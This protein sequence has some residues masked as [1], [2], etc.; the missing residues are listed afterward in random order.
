MTYEPTVK[1][2]GMYFDCHLTWA[3]H[4]KFTK[5]KSIRAINILK[6]VSG[7]NWGADQ[8]TL[9][10]LYNSLCKSILNYTYQIYSS[11]SNSNLK[12]LDVVHNQA[13]HICTQLTE[14]HQSNP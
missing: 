9:L 2:L 13:L 12:M 7:Y 10:K 14:L 4:L 8:I 5:T 6:V 3:Y 11:A 1:F